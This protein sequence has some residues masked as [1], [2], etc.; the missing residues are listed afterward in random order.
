MIIVGSFLPEPFWLVKRYQV[1][2]GVTGAG[3]VMESITLI[4]PS[5]DGAIAVDGGRP[6]D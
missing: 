5:L 3:V 2:S 4:E 6:S 1:Y